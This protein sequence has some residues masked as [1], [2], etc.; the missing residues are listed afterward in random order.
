MTQFNP[1]SDPPR[2]MKYGRYDYSDDMPEQPT[3][4][5]HTLRKRGKPLT[6]IIRHG[7]RFKGD[8]EIHIS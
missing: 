5:S 4:K 7:L 8:P 1:S 2:G 6:T 3:K